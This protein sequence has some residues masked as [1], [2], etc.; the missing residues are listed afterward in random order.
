[1][2]IVTW[3]G[4]SV[5]RQDADSAAAAAC[6]RFTA[7]SSYRLTTT[8]FFTCSKNEGSSSAAPYPTATAPA[9]A[10]ARREGSVWKTMIAALQLGL[11]ERAT[12]GDHL[13]AHQRVVLNLLVDGEL[14]VGGSPLVA[15]S[16][17][18]RSVSL[19]DFF[20]ICVPTNESF[21]AAAS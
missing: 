4:R 14:L 11:L 13:E 10:A 7:S 9:A 19:C 17:G 21:S 20:A 12:L 2:S 16:T 5:W 8:R 18:S 15:R 6:V 1:M 3:I